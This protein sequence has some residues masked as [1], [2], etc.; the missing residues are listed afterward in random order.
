MDLCPNDPLDDIDGDGVCGDVDNCP[1]QP[2][3]QADLDGD[4]VGDP[5]DNCLVTPNGRQVDTDSD[6]EGDPCDLDDGL[7]HFTDV[8]RDS[9]SWQADGIYL[10]FNLYRGDLDTLRM[11]AEY[12]QYPLVEH[13][14]RFCDL[15]PD[16]CPD[17]FVPPAGKGVFYLVT[18]VNGT[19]ESALGEDSFGR[20]RPNTNPCP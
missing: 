18:G 7:L 15:P 16:F 9:V 17:G 2:N 1:N 3:G 5:C 19:G 8:F 12:T 4:G 6:N 20:E 14:A 10:S 11:S 13:S